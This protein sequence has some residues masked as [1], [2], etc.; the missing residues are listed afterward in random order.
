[1]DSSDTGLRRGVACSPIFNGN[2]NIQN[3]IIVTDQGTLKAVQHGNTIEISAVG[4]RVEPVAFGLIFDTEVSFVSNE[5]P[6]CM[7]CGDGTLQGTDGQSDK[8]TIV[9]YWQTPALLPG[10]SP[11]IIIFK[12]ETPAKLVN[13]VPVKMPS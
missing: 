9:V 12:S 1:V 4:G 5:I 3:C 2:G 8:K 11:V 7:M 10:G 13:F 6:M